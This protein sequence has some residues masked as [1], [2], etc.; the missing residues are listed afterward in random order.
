MV[1]DGWD[2]PEAAGGPVSQVHQPNPK[3]K[4]LNQNIS[5]ED[6][7]FSAVFLL[8]LFFFSSK[9]LPQVLR[10]HCSTL[11]GEKRV[12]KLIAKCVFFS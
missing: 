8:N 3:T 12:N 9:E 7:F 4:L 2:G 10:K 6:E 11:F 1:G 5:Q